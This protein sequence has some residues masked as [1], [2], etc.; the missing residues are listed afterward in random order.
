M[1]SI[2]IIEDDRYQRLLLEE[3][4]ASDGHFTFSASSGHEALERMK[5]SA[6]DLVV[7]DIGLPGMDGIELLGKLLALNHELPVVIHTA[8]EGYRG[9]LMAWVADAYVLKQSDLAPLKQAVR[10]V[11]DSR[12]MTRPNV[13]PSKS[14]W[15]LVPSSHCE[16]P[17]LGG[18]AV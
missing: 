8:Y 10:R 14:P 16:T 5:A 15:P 3:E 4:L 13:A 12:R 11:L 18:D 7:L 1:A 17:H 6:P 2:L 9:N